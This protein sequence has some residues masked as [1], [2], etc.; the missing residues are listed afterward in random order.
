MAAIGSRHAACAEKL[1][2]LR[3]D[4]LASRATVDAADPVNLGRYSA[5]EPD[6]ATLRTD[7][8]RRMPAKT[9][10]LM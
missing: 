1:I 8:H 10:R 3:S 2:S 6:I 5:L 4:A 9:L 7:R